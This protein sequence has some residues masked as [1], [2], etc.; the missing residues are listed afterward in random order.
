MVKNQI[1]KATWP[2]K[3]ARGGGPRTPGH[4]SQKEKDERNQGSLCQERRFAKQE[5]FSSASGPLGLEST[6]GRQ[7]PSLV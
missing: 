2:E 1:R 3:T 7:H 6:N 5:I 4:W